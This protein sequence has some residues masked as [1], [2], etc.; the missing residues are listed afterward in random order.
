MN[1]HQFVRPG[2]VAPDCPPPDQCVS[3]GQPEAAHP[4]QVD[5]RV[6]SAREYL[7][8]IRKHKVSSLPDTVLIREAA[9][10][11]RQLGQVLDA[12]DQAGDIADLIKDDGLEPYCTTC[13]DWAGLFLGMDGWHHFTG[14]PAAGGERELYAADHDVTVGWRSL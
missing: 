14:D 7:A 4:A 13:G 6:T 10:L 3:C 11:R 1:G 12:I 8:S 9:E 2:Q 5:Q